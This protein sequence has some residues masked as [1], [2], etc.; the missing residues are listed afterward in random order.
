[1]KPIS[2]TALSAFLLILLVAVCGALVFSHS[3]LLTNDAARLHIDSQVYIQVAK[4][5]LN[6]KV[7]YRDVFDHK[8]P[9][10]Y[11]FECMGLCLFSGRYS[12]IWLIQWLVFSIGNSFLFVYWYRKHGWLPA[13][14]ALVFMSAWVFRT[15]TIG[16]NLPETFVA[17]LVSFFIYLCLQLIDQ[18][19][20]KISLY[21]VW[22]G[23]VGVSIF[24][25]KAN[26]IVLIMPAACLVFYSQFKQHNL[27]AFLLPATLAA[28]FTVLLVCFYFISHH[29]LTLAF[30]ACFTFN[31]SYIQ[32]QTFSSWESVEAVFFSTPNFLFIFI[33]L[34]AILKLIVEKNR[35]TT[36][37]VALIS[38]V[39]SIGVLIAIPGR[40]SESIHYAIPLAPLCAWLIIS[41]S[42]GFSLGQNVLLFVIGLYFFKP[43]LIHACSA[44][45]DS[46]SPDLTQQYLVAN[47]KPHETLSVWGSRSSLYWQTGLDCNTPYFY[48]YPLLQQCRSA[49]GE[50]FMARFE[51]NPANWIV[52]QKKYRPDT[53][54]DHLLLRY[55]LVQETG[56]EQIYQLNRAAP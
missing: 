45:T 14:T 47:K 6:G 56:D 23:I 34:V 37:F 24:L 1:M 12:G 52:C 46:P 50:N 39:L 11:W 2:L 15:K 5:L 41:V 10:M 21:S 40:G 19:K 36:L 22:M 49:I 7:L 26:F 38:L 27:R 9:V 16:D 43:V 4:Q 8:G 3:A 54:F 55:K 31:F 30:F 32:Q 28:V 33:V 42:S 51:K 53:C 35:R 48:T 29:A 18:H 13:L 44:G 25:I 17:G 20:V